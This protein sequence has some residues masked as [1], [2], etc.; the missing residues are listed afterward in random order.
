MAKNNDNSQAIEQRKEEPVPDFWSDEG[1]R[2][3]NEALDEGE[4]YARAG[5][6]FSGD[7]EDYPEDQDCEYRDPE[8]C[9]L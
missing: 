8:L 1:A 7:P 3:F 2:R 9:H 6:R 5:G 4:A